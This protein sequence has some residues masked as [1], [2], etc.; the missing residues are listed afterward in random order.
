MALTVDIISI[1]PDL[2]A[3]F[4]RVGMTGRAM[5]RGILQLH[6][7][8]LRDFTRDKHRSTDD[9]PYGG[10]SGMVMLAEPLLNA[11]KGVQEARGR[12]YRI[13]LTPGGVPLDQRLVHRIA[14][15]PHLVLIC[16]RYEGI[17]ERICRYVDLEL[18]LGDFI[19][20]G[21]ELAAL[22]LIDAVTRLQPGVLNNDGSIVEESFEQGV[23]EHPQYTRP[24]TFMGDEV[25]SVLLSGN[26][27][28]IR[29]WRRQQALLRTR[30][31]RPDLF[32]R[33][34]LSREDQR[35]LAE[36]DASASVSVES[37]RGAAAPAAS[38]EQ[39]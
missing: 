15:N 8:D 31:R 33:L 4:L 19:L 12:G 24:A 16:G 5:E 3:P 22:A 13:L 23:L 27:E 11:L 17:D 34:S 38:V 30:V 36:A 35:L 26:H 32:A 29:R 1:F 28:Q 20:T 7:S 25:P 39:S 37:D 2:F 6:C 10:G 18:S 9:T 21:G 14:E